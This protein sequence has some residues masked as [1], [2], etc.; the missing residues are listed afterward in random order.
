MKKITLSQ[1]LEYFNYEE[2]IPQKIQVV[3]SGRDWH[4]ADEL[5]V[6]SELL[7]P[8][9]DFTITDIGFE[10]SYTDGDPILRVSIKKGDYQDEE[11][12]VFRIDHRTYAFPRSRVS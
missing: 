7:D 12:V 3:T 11:K 9:L 8:F 10:K 1:L 6:D 4:E 2:M 5:Y